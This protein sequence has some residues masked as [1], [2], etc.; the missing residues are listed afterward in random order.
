MAEGETRLIDEPGKVTLVTL[1][2]ILP[3]DIIAPAD[4]SDDAKLRTNIA[5]QISRSLAGDLFDL[6]AT[7]EQTEAGI[8]LD[9]T[10]IRAVEAQMQ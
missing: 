10:A 7:A 6:Y 8:H 9:E 3:A 4:G 1:A 5:A 2:R